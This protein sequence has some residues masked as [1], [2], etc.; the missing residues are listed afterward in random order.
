MD[1]VRE[2][3]APNVFAERGELLGIAIACVVTKYLLQRALDDEIVAVSLVVD[4]L[5][6]I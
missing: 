1:S 6:P 5:A 2:P 4:D 3:D